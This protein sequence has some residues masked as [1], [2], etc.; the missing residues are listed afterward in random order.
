M[1]LIACYNIYNEAQYL[2]ESLKSI[3][4]KVDL[5]VVVDGAYKKFPHKIPWSTDGSL[6]IARRYTPYVI[7]RD[8]AWESE[9]AKRNAYLIGSVGD[10][11]L[12]IDGHEIW[13]GDLTPPFGNYRIKWKLSDG[14]HEAFRMFKHK[15][16]IHY[17]QFHY[18]IWIGNKCLDQDF[19]LYP[20]GYLIHKYP[21]YPK[22]R[23]E[24][25]KKYYSLESF[26]N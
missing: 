17:Q 6:E 26:D 21:D 16:G 15:L 12:V 4:D 24:A 14:W 19:P 8:R 18:S 7:E 13:S 23:Q 5:I 2:E 10:I 22:E 9:I 20:H 1:R 3:R 25:R 11:Y